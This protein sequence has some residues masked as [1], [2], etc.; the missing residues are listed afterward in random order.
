MAVPK[1]AEFD[2]E[3][4]PAVSANAPARKTAASPLFGLPIVGERIAIIIFGGV[5]AFVLSFIIQFLAVAVRSSFTLPM[6]YWV[7]VL[8]SFHFYLFP[9]ILAWGL[10]T[11]RFAKIVGREERAAYFILGVTGIWLLS[12]TFALRQI[13]FQEYAFAGARGLLILYNGPGILI[14]CLVF[15]Y[16]LWWLRTQRQAPESTSKARETASRVRSLD[17]PLWKTIFQSVGGFLSAAVL[18]IILVVIFVWLL[19]AD[20]F[21]DIENVAFPFVLASA[22]L[23]TGELLLAWRLRARGLAGLFWGVVVGVIVSA[24]LTAALVFL[25][26]NFSM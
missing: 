10:Q 15:A 24:L 22:L 5:S 25:I 7:A 20:V 19:F 2:A 6:T 3:E 12:L 17:A 13:L 8:L 11:R 14:Q 16:V 1:I 21:Q 4:K 18:F 9:P 23:Y 26:Y